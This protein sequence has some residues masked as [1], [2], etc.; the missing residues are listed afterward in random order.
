V[1]RERHPAVTASPKAVEWSRDRG[2]KDHRILR[3]VS[4]RPKGI[5]DHHEAYSVTRR[6][7]RL[8]SALQ[9]ILRPV[10]RGQKP[11]ARPPGSPREGVGGVRVN[12]GARQGCQRLD[13]SRRRGKKT[14][15][16][17]TEAARCS[18]WGFASPAIRRSGLGRRETS[19]PPV[20]P[21]GAQDSVGRPRPESGESEPGTHAV[22]VH[23]SRMG[24]RNRSDASRVFI[25]GRSQG[26]LVKEGASQE[27]VRSTD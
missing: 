7:S 21:Y 15:T 20:L 12:V 5:P 8:I 16:L 14:P 18:S 25:T 22:R 24:G 10:Y 9:R 11:T 17:M 23:V 1:A 26:Q 4:C 6:R 27:E 3:R 19:G 2:C 13:R